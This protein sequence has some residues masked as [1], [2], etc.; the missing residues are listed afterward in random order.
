MSTVNP[1]IVCVYGANPHPWRLSSVMGIARTIAEEHG[2]KVLVVDFD[3]TGTVLDHC[4]LRAGPRPSDSI[5]AFFHIDSDGIPV[6]HFSTGNSL[7]PLVFAEEEMDALGS[8]AVLPCGG[9]RS[10]EGI[11]MLSDTLG[12]AWAGDIL[13]YPSIRQFYKRLRVLGKGFDVVV[14]SMPPHH[15]GLTRS[16]VLC[17]DVVLCPISS[18]DIDFR[19]LG[20]MFEHWSKRKGSNPIP[21][22][23]ACFYTNPK[24]TLDMTS[25]HRDFCARLSESGYFLPGK[26]PEKVFSEVSEMIAHV[27]APKVVTE[28]FTGDKRERGYAK[29]IEVVEPPKKRRKVA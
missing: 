2:K 28:A 21:E 13:L 11:V 29:E 8:V 27:F 22:E 24:K 9:G 18:G 10:L 26:H 3:A 6:R 7:A 17:S 20:D 12:K 5:D 19:A 23:F 25:Q 16:L 14:F 15:E 1:K 4:S